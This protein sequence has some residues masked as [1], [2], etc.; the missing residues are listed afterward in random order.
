MNT[1]NRYSPNRISRN[2][3]IKLYKRSFSMM[4]IKDG[5]AAHKRLLELIEKENNK[6]FYA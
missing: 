6:K 4:R 5:G 2:G 3:L 1:K